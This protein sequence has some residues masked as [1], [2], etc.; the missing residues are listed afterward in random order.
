MKI[1]LSMLMLLFLFLPTMVQS[2]T[3]AR[4][5]SGSFIYTKTIVGNEII[6]RDRFGHVIKTERIHKN[7]KAKHRNHDRHH[8]PL[9]Y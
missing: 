3:F 7:R 1:I 4:D 8:S 6:Y 2:E 5:R 9:N